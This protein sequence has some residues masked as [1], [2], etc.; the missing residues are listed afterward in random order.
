MVLRCAMG[1]C[2]PNVVTVFQIWLENCRR[3]IVPATPVLQRTSSN[4][5]Q[6]RELKVQVSNTAVMQA[7]ASSGCSRYLNHHREIGKQ[8]GMLA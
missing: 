1:K 2:C 3:C 4:R 5:A 8:C 6:V 7:F